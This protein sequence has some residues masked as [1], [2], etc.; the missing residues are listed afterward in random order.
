MG[1]VGMIVKVAGTPST[2]DRRVGVIS[3]FSGKVGTAPGAT[4]YAIMP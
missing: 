2:V 1:K 4:E 3:S